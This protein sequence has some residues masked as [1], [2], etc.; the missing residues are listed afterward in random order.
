MAHEFTLVTWNVEWRA[1][2]SADASLIKQRMFACQPDII[3][4]TEAPADFFRNDDGHVVMAQPDYG[5]PNPD[6][7]RKVLLW[8]RNPWANTDSTG[9]P[10][11][12]SG[13]FVSSTTETTA[14][15][16]KVIGV[17]VPWSAAHVNT[18]RRDR[19]RWEEHLRYL[20]NLEAIISPD[21][22]ATV[23]IGDFNQTIPRRTAPIEVYAA[24]EESILSR[25]VVATTGVIDA[26]GSSSIDHVAHSRDLAAR[27]VHVLSRFAPSGRALSD[28]FGIMCQ[29]CPAG[30]TTG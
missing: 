4:L 9:H 20:H 28:H 3:C 12:P 1:A 14:G 11:L 7:R 5:Y 13:R 18:G 25:L 26:N 10:D 22:H 30:S 16:I 15:P 2:A 24:L 19:R 23:V 27:D 17:C 8:S 21:C 6:S 29:L